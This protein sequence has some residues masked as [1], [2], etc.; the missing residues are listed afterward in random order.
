MSDD[1]AAQIGIGYTIK[2]IKFRPPDIAQ[3]KNVRSEADQGAGT[4]AVPVPDLD[5]RAWEGKTDTRWRTHGEAH[6][7]ARAGEDGFCLIE[8][9]AEGLGGAGSMRRA[10]EPRICARDE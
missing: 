3:R 4:A 10:T 5:R 6:P 1:Q 7:Q 2:S 8:H 9:F